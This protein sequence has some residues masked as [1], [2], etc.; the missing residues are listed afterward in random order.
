M[1]TSGKLYQSPADEPTPGASTYTPPGAPMTALNASHAPRA[2]AEQNSDSARSE[3]TPGSSV[4][5][6][7]SGQRGTVV[8]HDRHGYSGT[9]M[10]RVQWEGEEASWPQAV[11]SNAIRPAGSHPSDLQQYGGRVGV[12]PTNAGS[13]SPNRYTRADGPI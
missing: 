12:Q 1:G 6:R 10:P 3:P 13:D 4:V 2:S 9:A 7:T 8:G 5:H 11:S